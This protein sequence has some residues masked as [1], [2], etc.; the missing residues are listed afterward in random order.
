M[1][2]LFG[3]KKSDYIDPSRPLKLVVDVQSPLI[4]LVLSD[5]LSYAAYAYELPKLT[6]LVQGISSN[7]FPLMLVNYVSFGLS[8]QALAVRVYRSCLASLP[9]S[10]HVDMLK[11]C[12]DIV[13]GGGGVEGVY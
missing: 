9:L 8:S 2:T 5:L 6:K 11:V 4:K 3:K 7:K 10:M 1:Y 13:G 12:I